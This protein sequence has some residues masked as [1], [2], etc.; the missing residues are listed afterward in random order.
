MMK[1]GGVCPCLRS[2][3]IQ[4]LIQSARLLKVSQMVKYSALSLFANRFYPALSRLEDSNGT[5]NWLLHP[6]EESNMQLFALVSLWV[7]S[8]LHDT[9]PL[10]VNNLKLLGDEFIKE[11]HYTKGDLLEAE[12]VLKF[13][14]GTSNIAFVLVE[15]LLVQFKAIARVGEH[16]KYEACMDVIDLLYEHEETTSLLHSSPQAL[17]ASIL[18]VAYVITVP[19]QKWDF[20]VLPWVMFVSSCK[21]EVILDSVRLI[22]KHIFGEHQ[23]SEADR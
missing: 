2:R 23:R 15:E 13:G 16:V 3:V 6:I 8:K 20:P 9:P 7:A 10:S 14:V 11:Q 4:F 22:L 17:A 18:V 12:L 1:K 21:E 19:L 5:K